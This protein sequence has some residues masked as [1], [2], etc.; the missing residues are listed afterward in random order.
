MKNLKNL[1]KELK[2]SHSLVEIDDKSKD[3]S[4]EEDIGAAFA[5]AQ[6]YARQRENHGF[7][8]H[9][10]LYWGASNNYT[11]YIATIKEGDIYLIPHRNGRGKSKQA[12]LKSLTKA[13]KGFLGDNILN[14]MEGIPEE[15]MIA[16]NN[17]SILIKRRKKREVVVL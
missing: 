8:Y 16:L 14:Q 6:F 3:T 11:G 4:L 17:K 12:S 5:V 1:L 15:K 2:D 9:V 13:T 7:G 10:H